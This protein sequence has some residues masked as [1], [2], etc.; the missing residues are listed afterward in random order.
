[1]YEEMDSDMEELEELD[2]D[3]E[4]SRL[5]IVF[6]NASANFSVGRR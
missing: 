2:D 6:D 1:M 4:V 5:P 3:D